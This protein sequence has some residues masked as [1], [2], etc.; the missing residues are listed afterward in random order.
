MKR[1]YTERVCFWSLIGG[2]LAFWSAPDNPGAL[3]SR[4][5]RRAD[6]RRRLHARWRGRRPVRGP[7]EGARGSEAGE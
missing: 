5:S 7:Q 4:R 1:Y 3:S 6:L 2:L